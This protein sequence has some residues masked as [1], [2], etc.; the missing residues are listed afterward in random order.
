MAERYPGYDVLDKRHT[1]SWNEQTRRVVD[2]R[3]AVPRE[4]RFFGEEEFATLSALCDRIVPQPQHRP[5]IP[6]AALIDDKM[7]RGDGHGYRNAKLPPMGEAW[8]R[9]LEALDEEARAAHGASFRELDAER[10]DE[11]LRRAHQGEL[12][13][14][15]WDGMPSDLFFKARV[16][17]DVTRAYYAHPTAWSMVG[18]G[19]PASP[20]G[21]VR[22]GFNRRDPWEAIELKD[23][24]DP[25]EVYAENRRVR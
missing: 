7:H 15:A 24:D 17:H 18:W 21:Y 5:P 25:A 4:P 22:M 14:P 13:G 2:E 16:L 10:Q 12:R 19:G 8:R 6:T 23:G 20:R 11:L 9:G 1:L 3:L